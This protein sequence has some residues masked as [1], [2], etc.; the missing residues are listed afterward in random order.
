MSAL[1]ENVVKQIALGFLKGYYR[2]RPR[3]ENDLSVS[4]VDME[5]Q[6]DVIVDGF[7]RFLNP[8]NTTFRATFEAS[9]KA[10][11]KEILYRP[12]YMHLTWDAL[13]IAS[14]VIA[15]FF[16]V[17]HIYDLYLLVADTNEAFW[18]RLI[19]LHLI[20]AAFVGFFMLLFRGTARYRYIYA[21]EQFKQYH[22]DDQ[23]VAYSYDVFEEQHPRYR[24]E[25]VR[26]CTKYGFGL[27]E[28]TAQR[29]PKLILAPSRAVNFK[30]KD[31]IM[32]LLP[33]GQ[34]QEQL[35]NI[36]FGFWD[37]LKGLFRKQFKLD[38]VD[39]FKWF[40]RTYYNQWGLILLFIFASF[41]FIRIEYRMLPF[42]QPN[43]KH[44]KKQVLKA[45]K[46][47]KAETNYFIVDAPLASIYDSL[48][49]PYDM[50]VNEERF[51]EII[52]Q[53]ALD[54]DD[55]LD[56][57]LRI[58]SAAAGQEAALYYS[59]NRF[60][61]IQ[62][63]FYLLV[64]TMY[65]DLHSARN[66]I[67]HFNEKGLSATAVWSPCLGGQ[68]DAFLLYV[69]EMIPDSLEASTLRDSLQL[70]LDTLERQ[71]QLI[72]FEPK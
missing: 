23:W 18:H 72:H 24:K 11:R 28:I 57:P 31:P 64:D 54:D 37:Q 3:A 19:Y 7:I 66:R 2:L 71:L 55:R 56:A 30:A 9:S 65:E 53:T 15:V 35:K 21:V 41:F 43:E 20:M 40:P 10:T 1:T 22:A 68:T 61:N 49:A 48:F 17:A 67:N 47:K 69:D 52:Q 44:Y 46:N 4:G 45:H 62:Q 6:G 36:S 58:V 60:A 25:L 70:Q 16:A 32:S 26:Q 59:C 34:W 12:R 63:A 14:L 51:D 50:H 27:V 13:V 42:N 29:K 33:S 38:R 39:Y 8:D 5:G